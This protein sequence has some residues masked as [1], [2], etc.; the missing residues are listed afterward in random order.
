MRKKKEKVKSSKGFT[1]QGKIQKIVTSL[2][3]ANMLILCIVSCVLNL[4]TTINTL[5]PSMNTLAEEAS[6]HVNAQIA[7]SLRQ[8]ELIGANERVS[9]VFLKREDKQKLLNSYIQAY[10]WE[11]ATVLNTIGDDIVYETGNYASKSYFKPALAGTTTLSEPV[12]DSATGKLNITYA[13][14]LWKDGEIGSTIIGVAIIIIDAQNFSD[15]MGSIHVSE[16]GFAY[17]VDANG[18]IIASYDYS[19]VQ[20]Q[21]N[22]ITAAQTDSKLSSIADIETRMINGENGSATYVGN[23]SLNLI[24]FTPVGINDW[25]IAVVA[26]YTDFS[27]GLNTCIIITIILMVLALV[28][29]RSMAKKLGRSIGEPISTCTNRLQLLAT[30]DLTTPVPEIKTNDETKILAQATTS[31]VDTQRAVISDLSQVLEVMASGNFTVNS[32]IGEEAY[33]GA[34]ATLIQSTKDL[35]SKLSSAL[36]S[37][38]EGANEVSASSNQLSESAQSV[39]EGATDQAGAVEEL[40]ATIMDITSR[41]EINA[42]ASGDAAKLASNVSA[43]AAGSSREI[44]DMTHAMERISAASE[45][46]GNIIGEIEDIAEQTNL[47]SLN[48]AIEAARAGEAGRGFAVVADQIRK[49]AEQSSISA[50]NTRKLIEAS[51]SEVET[52]N[53]ITERT[54]QSITEVI[55]GLETIATGAKSSYESAM[56]Q[57]ELMEQLGMG[58][59]QISE[60]IQGNSAIAQE[61]SATSEE[62][63]AQAISLDEL[64]QRFTIE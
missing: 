40:Q 51:L 64:T 9:N 18:T 26:P 37:I 52:G 21:T 34:Y 33:V 59:E 10:D 1:I 48:A 47:L 29:G 38:K 60:V 23:G 7:S 50:V 45:Q 31:I 41:V 16:N 63:S 46:I 58:V 20:E 8:V 24:A 56:E 27:G 55:D 14:P 6:Q 39:A 35:K 2:L 4:A 42:K 22:H 54:V 49:L 13:A 11:F 15:V 53:E 44:K 32:N 3:V 43:Q 5:V 62:L 30:G 36:K 61:V 19:Q 57:A 28:F 25:S 17:I 12:L